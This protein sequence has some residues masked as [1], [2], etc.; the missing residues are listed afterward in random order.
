MNSSNLY[1]LNFKNT[2]LDIII[3]NFI[4][5]ICE[6]H[7]E[8]N[9]NKFGE[10]VNKLID[11]LIDV[12]IKNKINYFLKNNVSFT[13]I[14]YNFKNKLEN[15]LYNLFENDYPNIETE[16]KNLNKEDL[17]DITTNENFYSFFQKLIPVK[18]TKNKVSFNAV[19]TE[20]IYNTEINQ[21]KKN[22][23]NKKTSIKIN[24]YEENNDKKELDNYQ[25]F[26]ILFKILL[27]N[28]KSL[29]MFENNLIEICRIINDIDIEYNILSPY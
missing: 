24:F 15:T 22:K 20:Y 10:K 1:I 6:T 13:S 4:D 18:N 11:S 25:I 29:K 17:K 8:E 7:K 5:K 23:K 14:K 21:K 3:K 12:C 27:R 16:I 2:N 19:A 28:D 9:I 26:G